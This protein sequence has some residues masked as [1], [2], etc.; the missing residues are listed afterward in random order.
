MAP[1]DDLIKQIPSLKKKLETYEDYANTTMSNLF[2]EEELKGALTFEAPYMS[3]SYVENLNNG[4]FKITPLPIEAQISPVHNILIK[5]FNLDGNKDILLG[6]NFTQAKVQFGRYDASKGTLLLGDGEGNF[7]PAKN[8]DIGLLIRGSVRDIE[9]LK[10]KDNTQ[11]ILV[12][13]NNEK[14]Q[15][16]EMN[17][18]I[19]E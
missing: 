4:T 19:K 6:G 18:V 8:K 5:D 9:T 2:T 13:K 7:D 16:L 15:V 17:R 1:R 14:I 3:T 11:L 12:G 10:T